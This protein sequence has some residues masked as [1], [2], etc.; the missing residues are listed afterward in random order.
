MH[1]ATPRALLA[2]F[3]LGASAFAAAAPTSALRPNVVIL[4]TDG[5]LE[6]GFATFFG[7]LSGFIDNYRHYFLHG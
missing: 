5:P 3:L 4:L 7:H 6:Q 2:L 1:R